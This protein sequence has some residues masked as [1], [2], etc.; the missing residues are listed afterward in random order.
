MTDTGAPGIRISQIF[1]EE[2]HFR[3]RPDALG[4]PH[5]TPADVG[6]VHINTQ[7]GATDEGDEGMIR[8]EVATDS[9][10]NP[11]Y[12]FRVAFVALVAQVEPGK[13]LPLVKY[14]QSSGT[15]LLF[16]FVRHAIADLTMKGRFGPI[17]IN[18]ISPFVPSNAPSPTPSSPLA[19]PVKSAPKSGK[20]ARGKGKARSK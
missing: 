7:I 20:S 2:A 8:I 18:P 15:L 10:N 3:H 11:T 16:P 17:W 13:G 14:L 4:L 6:R 12:E 9:A 1:L 19:E 5:T